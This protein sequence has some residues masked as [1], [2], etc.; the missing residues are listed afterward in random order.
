MSSKISNA[1]DPKL[2]VKFYQRKEGLKEDGE[3]GPHTLKELFDGAVVHVPLGALYQ[4][5]PTGY[6]VSHSPVITSG[7]CLRNPDRPTHYGV[8]YFYPYQDWMGA[9]PKGDGGAAYSGGKPKWWV[10]ANTKCRAVIDGTVAVASN[11]KTGYRVWIEHKCVPGF[12]AGYF[13]LTQVDVKVGQEVEELEEIGTVGD[14][15]ADFDARHLHFE[16]Y[17]G[18]LSEYPKGSLDPQALFPHVFKR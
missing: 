16:L 7:H 11:S 10:P 15:P 3:F 12:Y 8:D 5:H 2:M 13:H 4:T 17:Y 1:Y 9:V 14:N 18:D 6:T